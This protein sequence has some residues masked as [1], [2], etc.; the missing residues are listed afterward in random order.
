MKNRTISIIVIVDVVGA[1]ASGSLK[2]NIY[3]IDNNRKRG[4][5][6]EGTGELKTKVEMG[7][8]LIWNILPLE[9]EAFS[10]LVD[11]VIDPEY[12]EKRILTFKD[13]DITGWVGE[14]RKSPDIL[15]YQ[16]V[17][18]LGNEHQEFITPDSAFII[19]G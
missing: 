14:V 12:V 13:S 8:H 10:Q 11:I 15:P 2:D 18:K 5:E 17:L 4:S 19:G 9:P 1:L 7:D 16:L 3:F 6:K